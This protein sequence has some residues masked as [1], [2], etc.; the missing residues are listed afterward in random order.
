[1]VEHVNDNAPA[2]WRG[3][4]VAAP[5][6][7]L[8]AP[9]LG[10]QARGATYELTPAS[11]LRVATGSAGLLGFAG[12]DHVIRARAFSGLIV[13]DAA[14][15]SASRV[16]I[17][18]MTDSLEVLTPPDTAEIR[19]VTQAMR[20]DALHTD[21]YKEITFISR[22]VAAVSGGFHVVGALTMGGQTRNVP[23]DVTVTIR[24]DTLRATAMFGVKQTDFGIRPYR[25]GPGGLVRVADRVQFE[26]N[27]VA[28]RR[29]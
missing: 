9:P 15:P 4:V 28:L 1:M 23:V 11:E 21:R 25:G 17:R 19:K 18:I 14:T 6:I 5:L 3:V 26:I 13:F 27:A 29:N 2:I 10:V 8:A 7:L 12:H 16:E 24:S 22:S 20:T